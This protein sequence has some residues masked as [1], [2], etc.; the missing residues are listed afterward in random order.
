MITIEQLLQHSSGVF[1]VDNDPVPG[2]NGSTYTEYVME[3]DPTHQFTTDEM[4]HQLIINNLS[5]FAP[6]TNYHYSNTGYAILGEIIERVYSTKSGSAK[7]YDDYLKTY[8]TGPTTPVPV[9]IHFPVRADNVILPLPHV[10]GLILL[11]GKTERYSDYNMSGQVAEGNGY[12][13]MA[14]LNTYIRSL[15]KA[16][17][18]LKPETVKLMQTDVSSGN[19]NYGL[20]CSITPIGY[21]HNGARIGYLSQM[22]YDPITDVSVVALLPIWDLTKGNDSFIKCFNALTGATSAARKTLGYP[23]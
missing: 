8:V 18:V 7:T 3:K 2:F 14:A 4:I 17:N 12:G 19:A 5:Y 1:D 9:D 23:K 6:G 16:E 10:E 11:P 15:M 22:A 20:G 21:G 13:T